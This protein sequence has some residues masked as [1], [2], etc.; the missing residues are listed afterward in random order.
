MKIDSAMRDW[1]S[2]Q[3]GSRWEGAT[4]R[5]RFRIGLSSQV[6]KGTIGTALFKSNAGGEDCRLS[7]TEQAR[8][9]DSF[10]QEKKLRIC[11]IRRLYNVG[12]L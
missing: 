9:S 2:L 4:D 3:P 5:L 8:V 6:D 10:G 12:K 11:Q 1:G 7:Q